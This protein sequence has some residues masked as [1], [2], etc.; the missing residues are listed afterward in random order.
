MCAQ[1]ARRSGAGNT[2]AS[3]DSLG[4]VEGLPLQHCKVSNAGFWRFTLELRLACNILLAK[5]KTETLDIPREIHSNGA[6][7][8]LGLLACR[9]PHQSPASKEVQRA[10]MPISCLDSAPQPRHPAMEYAGKGAL[11]SSS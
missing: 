7:C 5:S 4:H 1:V 11:K 10:C 9:Q 6:R 8:S 2:N 3:I